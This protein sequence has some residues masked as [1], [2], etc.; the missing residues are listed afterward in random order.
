MTS[1]DINAPQELI[2]EGL[3]QRETRDE[4]GGKEYA[5]S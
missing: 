1:Q 4:C 2:G 5:V 3:M